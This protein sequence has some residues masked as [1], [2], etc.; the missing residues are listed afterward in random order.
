MDHSC[1]PGFASYATVLHSSAR[2][3]AREK[4]GAGVFAL[5][6]CD[7][8]MVSDDAVVLWSCDYRSHVRDYRGKCERLPAVIPDD[9]W[10]GVKV[11]LTA[12][13]CKASGGL[14][15]AGMM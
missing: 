9:T 8:C 6:D 4:I 5:Y 15:R 7:V 1:V 14:W 3:S 13:A 11:I 2:K 12:A 10:E